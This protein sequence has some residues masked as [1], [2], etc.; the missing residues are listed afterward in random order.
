MILL[1]I[2]VSKDKM[3]EIWKEIDL[4]YIISIG[5]KKMGRY[6]L[7]SDNVWDLF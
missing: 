3:I 5:G 6:F 1:F 4:G 7:L 2:T